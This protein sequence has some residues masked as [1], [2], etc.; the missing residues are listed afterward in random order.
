MILNAETVITQWSSCTFIAMSLGKE[1]Y[2][3]LNSSEL[4]KL[5]PKQNG[6]TSAVKIAQVCELVLNTPMPLIEQRRRTCSSGRLRSRLG[7]QLS[8]SPESSLN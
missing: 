4:K 8:Q 3:D 2:S 7:N 6:G 1:D 5:M